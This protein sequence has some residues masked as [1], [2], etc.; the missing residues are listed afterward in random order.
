MPDSEQNDSQDH[1]ITTP[2]DQDVTTKPVIKITALPKS[3]LEIE[4]SVDAN[5]FHRA[6]TRAT[7]GFVADVEL[8]GFRKGKAPEH[9]VTAVVGEAKIL[10]RGASIA[11][12]EIWADILETHDIDAIGSPSFQIT[13][14][15][16]GNP[17]EWKARVA[18]MPEIT[19]PKN[20]LDLAR[21]TFTKEARPVEVP[22]KDIDDALGWIQKSRTQKDAPAPVL[23]DAFA[24]SLGD[25]ATLAALREHIRANIAD[26]LSMKERER[27]RVTVLEKLREKSTMEIPEVLIA[28]EVERMLVDLQDMVMRMGQVWTDYVKNT[29]KTE[30]DIRSDLKPD[31][32]KRVA[33]GLV[34]RGVAKDASLAPS[35]EEIRARMQATATPHKHADGSM[36]EGAHEDDPRTIDYVTGVL[37][38]EKVFALLEGKSGETQNPKS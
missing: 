7:A 36:H 26:E 24:Q 34:L 10:E 25:F 21:E 33:F 17:L 16:R 9:M 38:N 4:G 20:Y 2:Q 14:M 15:A 37:T 27:V 1:E 19:L 8:K 31:A 29:G 22:E 5:A 6:L 32:E 11:L 30:S 35:E 12:S 13:K 18:V 28:S 23:D 3:E